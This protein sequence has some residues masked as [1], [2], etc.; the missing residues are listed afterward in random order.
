MPAQTPYPISGIVTIQRPG[1]AT[2]ENVEGARIWIWDLTEGTKKT[3]IGSGEG[4][5]ITTTNSSGQYLFDLA[6]ITSG[7]SNGDKVRVFCEVEGILTW[8]DTTIDIGVGA[9]TVN[10]TIKRR[11]GLKDGL[12]AAVTAEQRPHGLEHLGTGLTPGLKDGLN[13]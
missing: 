7:Y 2:A 9:S 8:E 12:K 4:T 13:K 1:G 3:A 6:N 5:L 11:S 10:F